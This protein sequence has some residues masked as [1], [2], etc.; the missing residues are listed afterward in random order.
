MSFRSV[1]RRELDVLVELG[2]PFDR[3]VR[4]AVL[5][6]EDAAHPMPGRHQERLDADLAADQVLRLL[7][8]LRRVDE[9]EA[10]AEAPVQ[11]H[12]QR[13]DRHALVARH[14]VG[15][16]RRLRHVEV[17]VA[18]EAPVPRRRI[19]VG[20]HG[21]VDAVR[22]DLALLEGA[23]DLVV[24]AREGERDFLGMAGSEAGLRAQ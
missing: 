19:H 24:A 22:L 5:V 15:R 23:H 13:G 10:V 8:A 14:D 11:E 7:D 6:L 21:E 4:H 17:A 18:D 2:E 16:A 12:R 1:V 20:E 3:L 9:H